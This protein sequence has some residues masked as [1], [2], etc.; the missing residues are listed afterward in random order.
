MNNNYV[1]ASLLA[2]LCV[3]MVACSSAR[4]QELPAAPSAQESGTGASQQQVGAGGAEAENATE[5]GYIIGPGDTLQ[6]F[7]WGQPELSVTVPVR[8]D[9]RVSTPLIDDIEAVGK[10]PTQL[11]RE[12]ERVLSEFVR[13]PEV[14]VIVQQF[15][16]TFARQVRV[17]GQAAQPRAVPYRERMTLLDVMIEVGGLTRFAAGNRSKVVRNVDGRTKEIRVKLDDLLNR[18]RIEEN[19]LMQPGD[20]VIIPEAVF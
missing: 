17:L 14:N 16:G 9:G 19:M 8:P 15:V 10:T 5:S 13:A 3:V 18:G 4:A 1:L 7:V 6:V 12:M 2:L 11:A 20:I